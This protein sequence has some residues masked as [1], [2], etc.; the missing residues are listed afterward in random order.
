MYGPGETLDVPEEEAK[1]LLVAG[2]V[3]KS[4]VKARAPK[5]K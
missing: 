3:E 4:A 2:Y 5:N 1:P